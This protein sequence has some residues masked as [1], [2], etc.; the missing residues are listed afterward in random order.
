MSTKMFTVPSGAEVEIDEH[1][2]I[3]TEVVLDTCALIDHDLEGVLDLL[4][5]GATDTDLLCDINYR[6][7]SVTPQG[8]IVFEVGGD[9]SMILEMEAD[10]GSA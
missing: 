3:T 7:L 2:Y 1:G 9:I 4:S 6:P 5:M 10:N 8:C